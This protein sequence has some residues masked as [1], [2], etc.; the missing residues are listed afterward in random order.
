MIS[1]LVGKELPQVA[2]NH[3]FSNT[4]SAQNLKN[5]FQKPTINTSKD[6]MLTNIEVLD[7][8][9]MIRIQSFLFLKSKFGL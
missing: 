9:E 4:D 1:G 8:Y 2:L 3:R 6:V 7:F 5:T